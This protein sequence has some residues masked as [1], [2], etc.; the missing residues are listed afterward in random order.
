MTFKETLMIAITTATLT[1]VATLLSSKFKNWF[2]WL[3]STN[4]FIRDHSYIQLRELYLE[5]Y[6]IVAQSEYLRHYSKVQKGYDEVP[7]I[8]IHREHHTI[9]MDPSIEDVVIQ[10]KDAVTEF[11]K[12]SIAELIIN[13]GAYASQD[14]L[15]LAVAYRFIHPYYK[16][17]KNNGLDIIQ[18]EELELIKKIVSSIVK[19]TNCYLKKC[20]MKYNKSEI[21]TGLMDN[22]I[23]KNN[24]NI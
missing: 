2:D 18:I 8:E 10:I 19:E 15:K 14:L 21:R 16:E 20:N 17:L 6:A 5:L 22:K 3:D 9:S 1:F 24:I 7:F 13:K 4:K 12:L 23:F 11:N